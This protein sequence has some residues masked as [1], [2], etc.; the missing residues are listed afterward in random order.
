LL[1]LTEPEGYMRVF[2]DEGPTM[3]ALLAAWLASPVQQQGSMET[4]TSAAYVQNLL[5]AFPS[6]VVHPVRSS[7]DTRREEAS[8]SLSPLLEPLTTREQDVLE[9]LAA[10]LS[11]TEIAARLIVTVGTVKT[12]IKSIYGKLGVHSR[13]QAIIRAREIG[14]L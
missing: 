6:T 2:V 13:T 4:K 9:L 12:H 3:Q 7:E 1:V 10:G 8:S 5:A 14:L 11:N